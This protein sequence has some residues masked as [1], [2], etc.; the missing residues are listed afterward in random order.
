MTTLSVVIPGCDNYEIPPYTEVVINGPE[1][2]QPPTAEDIA[3]F[4]E[5][6]GIEGTWRLIHDNNI[7]YRDSVILYTFT[8]DDGEYSYPPLKYISNDFSFFE[9]CQKGELTIRRGDEVEKNIPFEYFF[10][11]YNNPLGISSEDYDYVPNI[12]LGDS[13]LYCL[14]GYPSYM[15]LSSVAINPKYGN[16]EIA[17]PSFIFNR[18]E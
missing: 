5:M 8:V 4:L 14:R 11:Y 7:D 16:R 12:R 13:I 15:D 1:G 9:L 6:A 3:A 2:P 18:I 10:A 17:R